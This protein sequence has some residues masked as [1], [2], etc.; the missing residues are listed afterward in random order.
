M[1]THGRRLTLTNRISW[2]TRIIATANKQE[3]ARKLAQQSEENPL[4]GFATQVEQH[5]EQLQA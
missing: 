4:I 3:A 1:A 2:E 5:G